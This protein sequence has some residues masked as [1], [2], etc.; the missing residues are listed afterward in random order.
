MRKAVKRWW[1]AETV[2]LLVTAVVRAVKEVLGH[3][4][5]KVLGLLTLPPVVRCTLGKGMV[6]LGTSRASGSV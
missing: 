5:P 6:L 3:P 1:Q 4:T 2:I